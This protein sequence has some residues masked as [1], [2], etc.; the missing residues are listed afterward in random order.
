MNKEVLDNNTV[1]Y[2]TINPEL[3]MTFTGN[4]TI[5]C[6]TIKSKLNKEVKEVKEKFYL[7][8][9]T[10][11]VVESI[12]IIESII[13]KKDWYKK[14]ND[15]RINKKWIQE[16][17]EQ[18]CEESLILNVFKV[19]RKM[20][21]LISD[22][23]KTKYM[24]IDTL[25][26]YTWFDYGLS[27]DIDILDHSY[28]EYVKNKHK[29]GKK[30]SNST[31][32]NYY[33]DYLDISEDI[34]INHNEHKKLVLIDCKSNE[35]KV[36]IETV[37]TENKCEFRKIEKEEEQSSIDKPTL[38][39]F[40]IFVKKENNLIDQDLKNEWLKYTTN[41]NIKDIQP[42]TNGRVLNYFHPSLYPYIKGY[43]QIVKS[44]NRKI[45]DEMFYQWLA[46]DV[47]VNYI[48]NS[49]N[50]ESVTILSPI[51]NLENEDMIKPI[52]SILC[53]F[54]PSFN[55]LINKL[56]E[57]NYYFYRNDKNTSSMK[58]EKCQFIIKSQKI[59]LTKDN[60]VHP[61]GSL[62]LEG[63]C[64]ERII[65]TGI[66]YFNVKN[67]KPSEICFKANV[68]SD[69]RM[70]E[71]YYGYKDVRKIPKYY[72]LGSIETNEDT[73]IVFPNFLYHKVS[74]IEL[75]NTEEEGVREILVFWLV[76]PS[77]KILSTANVRPLQPKLSYEM[78]SI[79]RE[80]LMY[81]RKITE[82]KDENDNIYKRNNYG[83]NEDE[84]YNLCEH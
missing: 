79:H 81:E 45:D 77:R 41:Y 4:D 36:L 22:S 68:N 33:N 50:V 35:E 19:L 3:C 66:Y 49:D 64:Y 39:F 15:I 25:T 42:W 18:N 76:D 13:N 20:N 34:C 67:I 62:H 82:L 60:P 65:A 56:M 10:N 40:E 47:K 9:N 84:D 44:F 69:E 55:R 58:L 31:F 46:T 73:C 37:I 78:A 61:V 21:Q 27:I 11:P 28:C 23:Q 70:I 38:T 43:T 74:S 32:I 71:D 17:K 48:D 16:L 29:I 6:R 63:T 1:E 14:I 75:L 30:E 54:I 24:R 2:N 26:S 57:D 52:E 7:S 59:R 83:R 53:K 5:K 80:L 12:K 51:N 72:D 8:T